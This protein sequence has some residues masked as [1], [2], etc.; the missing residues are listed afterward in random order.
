MKTSK[1]ILRLFTLIALTAIN[2][3]AQQEFTLTT[4]K[5]NLVAS[6]A[7]IEMSGLS[8]N[9]DAIIVATPIGDAATLNPHSIGAWYYNGKWNI[10][11]TN[12]ANMPPGLKFK[13]EVFLKPDANHFLHIVTR[14]NLIGEGSEIDN[15]SFNNNPNAQVK[16][17]QNYAP[18]NRSGFSL[19][20]FEA[21]A[22]YNSASGKWYIANI[23]GNRLSPNTAY[24]VVVISNGTVGA[25]TSTT[26]VSTPIIATTSTPITS[27]SIQPTPIIPTTSTVAIKNNSTPKSIQLAFDNLNSFVEKGLPPSAEQPI[28]DLDLAAIVMAQQIS[29]SNEQSLPILLT[30]L[31]TAGFTIIDETGKVLRKPAGDGKGQG[32]AI[33]DFEAVGA[34]KL[35]NRGVNM[36]LEKIAGQIVKEV[37]QIS[38][39]QFAE[40]MLK[41]L[42]VQ[43]D[44]TENKFVRFWA[45]LVIELGK[46]SAKPIDLMTAS[47]NS[48][49]LSVLQATLITRRLQGDIYALK[50]KLKQIGMIP[51]P[52]SERNAFASN[53]LKMNY[54]PI[55]SFASFSSTKNPPC[56]L[57]GDEAL[58]LDGA[59]VGITAWNGWQ[60]G[61]LGDSPGLNKL[62]LGLQ[63]ANAALAW[64]KLIAA[65]VMLKGEIKVQTPLPLVRTT[66]A[67]TDEL[68]NKRL[69]VARVWQEVGRKEMLNC[70]RPLLNASTGLE[71]HLPT[72]GP[73]ADV[74]IEWHFVGDN[75]IRVNNADTRNFENFVAFKS[76]D[77]ADANPQKQVT[78]NLGLSKMWLVGAPKIPA[79]VYQ[80]DPMKVIKQAEVEVGVTF[81][82]SK[83]FIQNWID[84]GGTALGAAQS[85]G[86][87]IGLIGSLAELGYRVPWMAA[88]TTIPVEDHEPCE[89]QWVGTVTYTQIRKY[90]NTIT[91]PAR[92][93]PN[94]GGTGYFG[95]SLT[96]DET[97][98]LSGTATVNSKDGHDSL[99]TS[100][101][102]E[103][104]TTETSHSGAGYC[105]KKMGVRSDS[106]HSTNVKSASGSTTGTLTV[107]IHFNKDNYTVSLK[108]L[109]VPATLQSSLTSSRSGCNPGG[110]STS[111]TSTTE[112]GAES[113]RGKAS[114]GDDQNNLSGSTTT[115]S[116]VNKNGS[117]ITTITWKL[118]RCG[119]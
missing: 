57:T 28:E 41:N 73:L 114:I 101:A 79:V 78:D 27:P 51:T 32:L 20:K 68:R 17:L 95:G 4:T 60:F 83:D 119:Q 50:T 21:K 103:I 81:K 82:S 12:H 63:G 24:N 47:P 14:Q 49:S 39:S 18:D 55:F 34:L 58:I 26:P 87:S 31:Q 71:F 80:K 42:Q 97:I 84:I 98:T 44:N 54:L 67:K 107:Y 99:T 110:E 106:S 118:K 102:D 115:T 64:L 6:K 45:R 3:F 76:F 9:S 65:V 30:A 10:F 85:G 93:P 96:T 36:S 86:P 92:I 46:S 1:F 53:L 100:S 13:L 66:N 113:I 105:N 108:P 117:Y 43:A 70:V 38:A 25:N 90:K 35:A 61:Q 15:P 8:G 111:N 91:Y 40:L 37:P 109:F 19:N 62:G 77:G 74:A 16:I 11:N 2:S 112:Y 7:L 116:N 72:D 23:N 52:F 22:V 89:G 48:V 88:K 59:A 94:S 56:N 75:E 104:T 33:Y 69:M 5:A 29:K